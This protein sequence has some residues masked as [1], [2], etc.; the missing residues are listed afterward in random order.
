MSLH[1]QSEH[2]ASAPALG[3]DIGGSSIKL[4][5]LLPNTDQPFLV[6]S[7]RYSFPDAAPF[8][9][10]L[11]IVAHDPKIRS[12]IA[13]HPPATVGVCLPGVWNDTAGCL[14]RSNNLPKLVGV[15][16]R[17]L[18]ERA[19]GL[20]LPAWTISTD[21]HATAIDLWHQLAPSI[22]TNSDLRPRRLFCLALGTGVG[23]CV[24][25]EGALLRIN[26]NSSGH[27]GQI[28]VTVADAQPAPTAADGGSGTLE[29]YWAASHVQH[30][31]TKRSDP[32]LPPMLLQ[33]LA[34][35]LRIAHAI[36][37]P[38]GIVLAGGTSLSLAPHLDAIV[39]T[40]RHG[41]SSIAR[42]HCAIHLATHAH[43]AA[44][45]IARLASAQRP[46]P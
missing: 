1:A 26:G 3:V 22:P 16:L 10:A 21:V 44:L 15:P 19:M 40:M 31:L 42:P 13:A 25:D 27:F 14:E 12:A 8:E 36:Y 7:D 6:Q 46:L 23:A 4:A 18:L 45:G 20:M 24:L 38:D 41:L 29:A 39:A 11:H 17:P 9:R 37:R 34:R 30:C 2:S 32:G 28:D 43:H 33:S 5:L 35:A